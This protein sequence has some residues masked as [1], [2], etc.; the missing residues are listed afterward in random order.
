MAGVDRSRWTLALLRAA[1]SWLAGLSVSGVRR[2]AR[3]L[4]VTYRRGQEQLHS[5][6]PAYDAKLAAVLA[7]RAEAAASGG[8][9]AFVYQD[10]LTY[11]RRPE[12]GLTYARVGGP[13]PPAAQGH[14]TNTTRRVVG[15]LD[16]GTGRLF[17]WQRSKAG[18]DTLRL[19]FR[20]LAA[21]Y[22]GAR[23]VYVAVDNWPVHFNARLLAALPPAV[24]LLR[25]PTYAP[26]TNPIEKAWRKLKADVLRQHEF[27]ADWPGLQAAVQRWLDAED[28]PNPELLRYVG[29][30]PK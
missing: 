19:Y 11:Y 12:P 9:V 7:A 16:A 30:N 29:L 25:L 21:R 4:G 26:W 28:R 24:R 14:G 13:G 15:A 6:D 10:E 1:V 27:A 22:P 5:P 20:A 23:T 8:A 2:V 3:R 17:C 18:V